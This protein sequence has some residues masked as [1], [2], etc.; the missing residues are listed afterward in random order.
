MSEY[1]YIA[2]LS[3]AAFKESVPRLDQ[4]IRIAAR[5]VVQLWRDTVDNGADLLFPGDDR[6]ATENRLEYAHRKAEHRHEMLGLDVDAYVL[7]K[8][9]GTEMT[10]SIIE[11]RRAFLPDQ[12]V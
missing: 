7:E 9:F 12:E 1:E 2:G 11:K 10:R 6:L 5:M 4:R 3:T 8:G